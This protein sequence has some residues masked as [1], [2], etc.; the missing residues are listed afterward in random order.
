M[1]YPTELDPLD[2]RSM[3]IT[4]SYGEWHELLWGYAQHIEHIREDN[5]VACTVFLES[6]RH[7]FKIEI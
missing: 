3:T 7:R 2:G 4:L 6:M 5:Q 1:D